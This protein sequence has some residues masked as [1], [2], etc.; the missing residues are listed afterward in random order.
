MPRD[1]SEAVAAALSSLEELEHQGH[2]K[3]EPPNRVMER[4]AEQAG[5]YPV[6][7]LAVD[8][9][10]EMYLSMKQQSIKDGKKPD[11]AAKVGSLGY[12]SS[13]PKLTNRDNVRD[14]IACVAHGMATGVIP[15]AD[16]T[17]L[18]YAAQ[19]AS[20]ALPSPMRRKKC[21]KTSQIHTTPSPI[22]PATPT[23]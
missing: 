16:G 17:R 1:L 13:L 6:P 2:I 12:C 20:T 18:L 10:C 3:P 11:D 8:I 15:G 19:I 14:F 7:S 23:T 4:L 9:C 22:T 5:I 21:R